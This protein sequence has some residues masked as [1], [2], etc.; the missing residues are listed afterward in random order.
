MRLLHS[1]ELTFEDFEG[2]SIPKYAILSHTWSKDE[3][4]LHDMEKRSVVDKVGYQKILHCAAV[5]AQQDIDYIWVDTC[6]IDKSSSAELTE[7]INSMYRWYQQAQICYA[8]LSDVSISEGS[9]DSIRLA[10]KSS[11]W[12]TRGWTLQ[13]LLAPSHLVFFD[14]NWKQIGSKLDLEGEINQATGI[15][16]S[17]LRGADLRTFTIAQRMCWAS[18]RNTTRT[19]DLAYCL[20]GIFDVNMPLLYGEGKKSFIRLQEEIMKNTDDQTLFAWKDSSF[21][22]NSF[23]GLLAQAPSCFAGSGC[24]CSINSWGGNDPAETTNKGIRVQLYMIGEEESDVYIACLACTVGIFSNVGPAIF[25]RRDFSLSPGFQRND[26]YT[27]IK[28]GTL[29]MLDGQEKL[30]GRNETLYVKPFS[31][32]LLQRALNYQDSKLFWI[33]LSGPKVY[34]EDQWDPQTKMFWSKKLV[35]T[36]GAIWWSDGF[37]LPILIIFGISALNQ[38]WCH[39]TQTTYD[40][41]TGWRS[42]QPTGREGT[43]SQ[44]SNRDMTPAKDNLARRLSASSISSH[45]QRTYSFMAKI[46]NGQAYMMPVFVITA[47]KTD[48]NTL[49]LQALDN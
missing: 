23:S 24:F 28:P 40:D 37:S 7:A 33:N 48:K 1:K 6:C 39:V 41:S 29:K 43:T 11:K 32:I 14:Q 44:I 20:L 27:R 4:S 22:P 45:R 47:A 18:K 3:V 17:A 9:D 16:T 2:D 25:L 30:R 13:E 49:R 35:G 26:V 46:E 10:F 21:G 42:Y 5:A 31:H 19:E 8:Y 36:L 12:F 38:P 34:P 15:D